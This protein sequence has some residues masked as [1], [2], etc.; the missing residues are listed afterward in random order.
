[1]RWEQ[2]QAELV[3][4][5]SEPLVELEAGCVYGTGGTA[6][7]FHEALLRAQEAGDRDAD[8]ERFEALAEDYGAYAGEGFLR[9]RW[10]L[11]SLIGFDFDGGG[12]GLADS[13]SLDLLDVGDGRSY[14][15]GAQVN[16]PVRYKACAAVEGGPEVWS[17]LFIDMC[18]SDE[19]KYDMPMF[20]SLPWLVTN[21]VPS[22]LPK[23]AV[24]E[25]F[26]R[27]LGERDSTLGE[28]SE[29]AWPLQDAD[30]GDFPL[31]APGEEVPEANRE[32]LLDLYFSHC[33]REEEK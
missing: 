22:L 2:V 19:V 30:V 18:A 11:R 5:F 20:G 3:D 26:R 7:D 27:A 4:A 31:P 29:V 6:F 16:E 9:E 23:E 17:W 25:G 21:D 24:Q 28:W 32:A 13:F 1:M 8:E 33:Y 12:P 14:V 10:P 15:C